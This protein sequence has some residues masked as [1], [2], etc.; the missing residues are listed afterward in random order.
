LQFL[1]YLCT[2]KLHSEQTLIRIIQDC[3]DL[4]D[5]TNLC[6]NLRDLEENKDLEITSKMQMEVKVQQQV[7]IFGGKFLGRNK[8]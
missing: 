3:Y 1:A 8:N 4:D 7:I 2:V 5:L 6:N